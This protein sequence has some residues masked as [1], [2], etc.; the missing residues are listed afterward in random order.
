MRKDIFPQITLQSEKKKQEQERSLSSINAEWY[1]NPTNPHLKT[2][3]TFACSFLTL[4]FLQ[5]HG[6]K[7]NCALHLSSFACLCL[8][9][10]YKF[11][12][13]KSFMTQTKRSLV[14]ASHCFSPHHLG[15]KAVSDP[16]SEGKKA[17]KSIVH[18][19]TYLI[20]CETLT[21]QGLRVLCIGVVIGSLL[22]F[23][24]NCLTCH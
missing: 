23:H 18:S 6:R 20:C 14:R 11:R 13:K 2:D 22:H 24:L 19:L 9:C 17:D 12:N 4:W 5:N 10:L 15:S 21:T 1:Q 7:V 8:P 16:L 3:I